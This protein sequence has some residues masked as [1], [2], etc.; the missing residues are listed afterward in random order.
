M[1]EVERNAA[2]R[3]RSLTAERDTAI[4]LRLELEVQLKK[5]MAQL[6]S[7]NGLNRDLQVDNQEMSS[8]LASANALQS[9]VSVCASS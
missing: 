1:R 9:R 8:K 5:T 2:E 3:A 6:E 7:S 4:K